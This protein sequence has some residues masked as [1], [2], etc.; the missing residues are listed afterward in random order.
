MRNVVDMGKIY[1]L[2]IKPFQAFSLAC[3][4]SSVE[5]LRY[6]GSS[7]KILEIVPTIN[8]FLAFYIRVL[9]CRCS[10]RFTG[11]KSIVFMTGRYREQKN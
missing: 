5:R 11:C 2:G 6:I 3:L 1:I 9:D 4:P 7:W 10:L 8:R